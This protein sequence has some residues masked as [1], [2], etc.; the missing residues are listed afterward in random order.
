HPGD[1]PLPS[2][3]DEDT[4]AR[5]FGSCQ[6]AV[7]FILA[8]T[9]KTYARLQFKVGPRGNML[10][11]VEVDYRQAF[12]ASDHDAWTAEYDRHVRPESLVR[13]RL[14]DGLATDVPVAES[15]ARPCDDIDVSF[16]FDD[17]EELD[18]LGYGREVC[19]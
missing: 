12:P 15:P 19:P 13:S 3:T 11:P 17:A 8:R 9:G 16:G 4:F 10:I 18:L 5:V 1:S 6:W 2:G 7:M 14:G